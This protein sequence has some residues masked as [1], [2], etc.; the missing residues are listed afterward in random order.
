MGFE[1]LASLRDKLAQQAAAEE[2]I[3]KNKRQEA[4][5][6]K[7]V[8]PLVLIIGTLQKKFPA[9]FPKNPA[10]K[11]PLKIGIHK[12]ILA[13]AEQLGIDKT[14]LRAAIKRWCWGNRYWDC[15]LEGAIRLDLEGNAV[16][17]VSKEEAERTKQLKARRRKKVS[18]A[19]AASEAS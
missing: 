16:G 5:S 14:D 8:D 18:P 6:A 4:K 9:A 10:P 15:L 1:Q 17:E 7:K 3:K 11:V 19:A 13:Q 2:K 12:D